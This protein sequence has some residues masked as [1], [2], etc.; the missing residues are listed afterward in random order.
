MDV[1]TCT[2][3]LLMLCVPHSPYQPSVHFPPNGPSLSMISPHTGA[4]FLLSKTCL[5]MNLLNKCRVSSG[6]WEFTTFRSCNVT[7]RVRGDSSLDKALTMQVW[8]PRVCSQGSWEAE[9]SSSSAILA[10]Y[11]SR[12]TV[13]RVSGELAVCKQRCSKGDSIK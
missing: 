12:R 2:S 13:P 11:R 1:S 6:F 3:H 10:S 4:N 7:M 9:C 8:Q 5:C